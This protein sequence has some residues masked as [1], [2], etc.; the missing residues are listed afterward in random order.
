MKAL[1]LAGGKGTR[2]RPFT[3][4]MP[5][6]LIPVGN[7][8]VLVHCL[9]N[10]RDIGVTEAGVIVGDGHEQIRALVGDGAALGLSVTYLVQEAPLGLAHAVL[11]ARE[12]LGGDDFVMYLG[13]NVL[14][15]GIAEAA[16]EFRARRPDARL[17]LAKVADPRQYGVAELGPDGRVLSLAEKPERPR[18][19]LAITGVYFF[20][21]AVHAAVDRIRPSARGELEIT[22]A[23]RDLL[24]RGHPVTAGEYRGY[25]RDTG[26]V[27]ELLD[28][29]RAVLDGVR[30]GLHGQVDAH[31]RIV[32]PVVVEPDARIVRSHITGPAVIGAAALVTDSRVGA[33]SAI[34][35]GCT[36][37]MAGIADSIVLDGA[38]ISEMSGLTRSLIGRGATVAGGAGGHSSRLLV[39]D[40]AGVEVTA[41]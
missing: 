36:L 7:K 25:W 10:I 34:G 4:S 6:Q 11:T 41:S 16:A 8:P 17:L 30:P 31:S 9:E 27:D 26:S 23:V 14:A 29:N 32:G 39:G 5:K 21:P 20:T 38:S 35:R 2:L 37:T 12:Y 13:D 22:D 28:C 3:H 1:V 40:D 33:Y 15:G 24:D 18:S 19:D